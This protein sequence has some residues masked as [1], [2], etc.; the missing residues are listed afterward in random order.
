MLRN[1]LSL[2][3]QTLGC[4]MGV[5]RLR[6]FISRMGIELL[7]LNQLVEKERER[8]RERDRRRRSRLIPSVVSPYASPHASPRRVSRIG[9]VLSPL[10]P[11]PGSPRK[12][13]LEEQ[14]ALPLS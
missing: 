8:D 11:V 6:P 14:V 3:S 9:S 13:R 2:M 4:M 7:L 5:Y 1:D 10:A 12:G